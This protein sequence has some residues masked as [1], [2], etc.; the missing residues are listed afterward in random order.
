MTLELKSEYG[1]LEDY[2]CEPSRSEYKREIKI[3]IIKEKAGSLGPNELPSPLADKIFKRMFASESTKEFA[4]L[5]IS[6]VFEVDVE[7]LIENMKLYTKEFASTQ[8]DGRCANMDFVG[9]CDEIYFSIKMNN[10]NTFERNMDYAHRLY[11]NEAK[12]GT[13]EKA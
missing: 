7:Y 2:I 4:C 10:T 8:L 9:V 11:A 3:P 6:C 1:M 12:T 13:I 5:L